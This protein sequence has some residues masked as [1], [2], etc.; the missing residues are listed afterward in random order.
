MD[1]KRI[2]EF[3]VSYGDELRK[4]KHKPKQL[5]E[6]LEAISDGQIKNREDL[7][8]FC[9]H[10]LVQKISNL[11]L[12]FLSFLILMWNNSL[13]TPVPNFKSKSYF[14]F[15]EKKEKINFLDYFEIYA[16]TSKFGEIRKEKNRY[17]GG[18][19]KF[20][21]G[22]DFI[23]KDWEDRKIKAFMDGKIMYKGFSKEY[24]KF[25]ITK[26]KLPKEI[27][28]EEYLYLL[29]AHCSRIYKKEGDSIFCNQIIAKMGKTGKANGIHLHL[30]SRL[31]ENYSTKKE[32]L[33]LEPK[34][35]EE[36]VEKI[37]NYNSK[38]F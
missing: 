22:I 5:K 19:G 13:Y 3:Y 8:R 31:G 33:E 27:F 34:N 6:V 23:W 21:K 18:Y 25:F 14:A 28:G 37:K 16:V 38:P 29:Y 26:H 7:R 35:F 2:E 17:T 10:S 30:E 1:I 36:V 11:C 4:L 24:G 9:K 12:S 20:H 32:I 15:K